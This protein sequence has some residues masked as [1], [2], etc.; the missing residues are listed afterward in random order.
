MATVTGGSGNYIY[1]WTTSPVQS[2]A[3]A[4]NLGAGTYT[5]TVNATD[6]CS[7]TAEVIIPT[8]FSC[9]GIYFPSAFTPNGDGLND[10][11]GP[12]GSLSSLTNY[13]L[14]IYNR[15]GERVFSTTNPFQKWSGSVKGQVAGTGSFAW[16]AEYLLPGQSRVLRKGVITMIR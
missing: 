6:A 13:S 10:S 12:L 2:T 1:A 3:T 5:V 14:S 16:Y 15:W 7:R 8:D 4:T 11:F 9:I